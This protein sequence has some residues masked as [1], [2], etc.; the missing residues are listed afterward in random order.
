PLIRFL[1]PETAHGL[2]IKGLRAGLVPAARAFE[3]PGLEQT[4]WGRTFAN[5][6]GLAAGFDKNAEVTDAMLEQG[7]G[8]VEIG[9]VTPLAQPGN[10][11]PRLFRLVADGAVINRMGFNNEGMEAVATRLEKRT[12]RGIVGVNLGKNK[13]SEDA[14]EDYRKGIFRLARFADYL[15]IN[16]SS[17]N[18][19]GLRA[20]QGREPL[21]ELL[22]AVLNARAESLPDA[23]PPLLLKIAP[24]LTDEDK[25]DIAEVAL[26]TG[27]DGLIATNTTIERPESL[28]DSNAAET[29]GLSGKPLLEPSTRVLSEMYR[30]TGGKI[31]LVGVGGIAS[32]ADAYAKI[33]AG[34]TLIQFYS[35]MVYHGP[36]LVNDIKRELAGLVRADGYSS[37]S[38]AIGADHA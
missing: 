17:P 14:I 29:G 3:D 32:G 19:P 36:G 30:R 4:V 28:G 20:L 27:I 22:E 5:P 13:L 26:A 34:A 37:I 33:R 16:V 1:D 8:F 12:R 23:P 35:A 38:E 6:V 15:V 21:Q 31:P 25:T 7:F 24:D 9:S 2:A 18:T 11:R 10:P